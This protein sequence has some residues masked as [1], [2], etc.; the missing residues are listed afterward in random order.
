MN[1]DEDPRYGECAECK[2]VGYEVV[3]CHDC[4][5][6]ICPFCDHWCEEEM[7]SWSA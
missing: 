2:R 4:G 1:H 7:A 5:A 3:A 6:D